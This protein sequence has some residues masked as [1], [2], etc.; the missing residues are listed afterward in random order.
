VADDHKRYYPGA[1]QISL[2]VTGDRDSGPLIGMQLV[3]KKNGSVA[4]RVD[5]AA[6]ALFARL[7]VD[8]LSDMDLA[9]TLPLGSPWDAVRA[10]GQHRD[11]QAPYETIETTAV[12][13]VCT[14]PG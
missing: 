9:Y 3:G 12:R 4:K 2:R 14:V 13:V 1:H 10:A 6:T 8:Q 5:I 11:R 7:T